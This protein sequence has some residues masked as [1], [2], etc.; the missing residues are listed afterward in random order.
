MMIPKQLKDERYRFYLVANNNKIPIQKGWSTVANYTYRNYT[1]INH[2]RSGGN[3]GIITGFN[4]LII[5]DFDSLE[6]YN[7]VKAKLP[8]TFVV[9]TA[10]SKLFHYYYHFKGE[11]ISKIGID[12]EHGKRVLDIQSNGA[13]IVAPGSKIDRISY[14]IYKDK[15]INTITLD[16]LKELFKIDEVRKA[17]M[18]LCLDKTASNPEQVKDSIKV[19]KASGL[20]Q[21]RSRHFKCPRHDMMNTGNLYVMDQGECYC[22]HCKKY[23]PNA[24]E[25]LKSYGK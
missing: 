20:K 1:L 3:W 6:F 5:L 17:K 4:N 7:K 16:K 21:V 18:K 24:E 15:P 2:I 25:W 11:P 23:A 8:K 22:F 10:K 12:D 14:R 13:G 19:L 9:Q